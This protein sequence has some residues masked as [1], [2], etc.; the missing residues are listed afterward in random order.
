MKAL[1][2]LMS[3]MLLS[4]PLSSLEIQ[5]HRG[6][7]GFYPENSLPGFAAAIEAGVEVLELDLHVTSDKKVVIHHDFFLNNTLCDCQE[8]F[9]KQP[10][11]ELSLDTIQKVTCGSKS[12]PLF[13]KQQVIGAKIPSLDEL[14]LWLHSSSLPQA[15]EV[16]LNLE[17]KRDPTH[18]TW[19][20]EL[21][22]LVKIIISTVQRHHFSERVYYSSFDPAV[23]RAIRLLDSTVTL[24]L[25]FEQKSLDI[26]R[27]WT[28]HPL[29]FLLQE[30][31][32]IPV[33]ILSPDYT[34]ITGAS[35]VQAWHE[36]GFKV[37][38][39]TINNKQ[40]GLDLLHMGVDGLI[41]DYPQDFMNLAVDAPVD[42]L[43]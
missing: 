25:I 32:S 36:A 15:K 28:E 18:P 42:P 6:A 14:L 24:G 16:R 13:P 10:L 31:S 21:S 20:A 38:P 8:P 40:K 26:A 35:Q 43:P 1:S 9:L 29:E 22:T 39:W 7:R 2:I 17:I 23:L 11:C 19:S 41:S 3:C 34:L 37:I 27:K 5:G 33:Q 4:A 12:H 30:A